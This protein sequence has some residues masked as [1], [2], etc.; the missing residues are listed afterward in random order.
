M[1]I[2]RKIVTAVVLAVSVAVS[3]PAFASQSDYILGELQR[4]DWEVRLS[5][6]AVLKKINNP[7]STEVLIELIRNRGLNW[8]IQMRGIRLLGEIHTPRVEDVLLQFFSDLFFHHGCPAVRSSLAIALGNF[9]GPK[10]VDALIGGLDDPEVIVREAS[11]VSLGK[12]GDT[13]AV[14]Y[15]IAQLKDRRFLIRASAIHSLGL[16]KDATAVSP[17]ETIAQGDGEPLLRKEA[18]SV[19]STIR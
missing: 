7:L 13:R 18:L 5:N 8:R 1:D 15:L 19:L 12:V 4:D 9:A 17:L 10:V 16:L 6:K 2:H 14:P 11:I 3:M